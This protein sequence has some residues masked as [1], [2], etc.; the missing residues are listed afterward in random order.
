MQVRVGS[1]VMAGARVGLVVGLEQ[2]LQDEAEEKAKLVKDSLALLQVMGI[3][4][5]SSRL[6]LLVV[7]VE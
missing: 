1:R 6:L 2:R 4:S 5:S 7:V 3:S